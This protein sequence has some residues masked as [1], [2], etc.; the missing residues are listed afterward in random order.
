[1][2]C[3]ETGQDAELL[4]GHGQYLTDWAERA[5]STLGAKEVVLAE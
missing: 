2:L 1:M 4:R 3:S 5:A